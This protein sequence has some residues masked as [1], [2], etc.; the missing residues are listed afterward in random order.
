MAYSYPSTTFQEPQKLRALL[1]SLWSRVYDGRD[2][3]L[4]KLQGVGGLYEQLLNDLQET[5]LA[6]SRHTVP[7]L[8]KEYWHFL[9]LRQSELNNNSAALWRFDHGQAFDS[10]LRFDSATGLDYTFDLP[11]GLTDAHLIMN[12]I[13][14]PSA[15]LHKNL[16]FQIDLEARGLV[17]RENPFDNPDFPQTPVFEN[18]AI[19]DYEIKL[20]IFCGQFDNEQIYRQFG[21]VLDLHR[22]SSEEYRRLVNAVFDA[23]TGCTAK[24]QLEDLISLMAD[25]PLVKEETE[26]VEQIA[27]DNRFQWIITDRHCYSFHLDATPTVAVGDTVHAGDT[28]TSGIEKLEFRRGELASD[29]RAIVLGKGFL[30]PDFAGELVFENS[31]QAVTLQDQAVSFPIGGLPSD[32]E[33]FWELVRSRELVRGYSLYDRLR[34]TGPIPTTINPAAFLAAN[35]LRNNAVAYRVAVSEFGTMPLDHNPEDLIRRIMP[36]RSTVLL[37]FELSPLVQSV[38]MSAASGVAPFDMLPV[39]VDAVDAA[40]V[41]DS[42]KTI[43]RVGF[44]CY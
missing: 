18:G 36:P 23:L 9:T 16:D 30:S 42:Y 26:E 2:L 8:H 4:A 25:I 1:G 41:D 5:A 39:R 21:Y 27:S 19:A 3:V 29:I 13:T 20:A 43:K 28:L 7:V 12:R 6:V 35:V 34:T 24:A 11:A 40:N 33:L 32:V 10:G 14:E 22:T 31:D 17:F 44:N 37:L 15:V 38:T